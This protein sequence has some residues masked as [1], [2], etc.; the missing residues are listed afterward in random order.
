MKNKNRNIWWDQVDNDTWITNVKMPN[1]NRIYF[2]IRADGY[3]S[4]AYVVRY[5]R[6]RNGSYLVVK[7]S[8][9]PEITDFYKNPKNLMSD[10]NKYINW[11]IQ[12]TLNKMVSGASFGENNV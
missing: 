7:N 11:L 6:S 3:Y 2:Q 8:K 9:F 10:C 12:D 1:G 4:G 5:K